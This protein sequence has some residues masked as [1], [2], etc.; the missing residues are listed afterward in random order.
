MKSLFSSLLC[1]LFVSCATQSVKETTTDSS[2]G[3]SEKNPIK[4]GGFNNGPANQ[5]AYLNSLTGPNGEA[6]SYNRSGSCCHF[7]TKSSPYG[8]GLLDKYQVTYQNKKDTVTLYINM[9]DKGPLKAP[10][11]FKFK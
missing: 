6:L 3:Y 8:M 1:A 9:Y 2:Y 10:V 7:E 5:R 11:G 4:V